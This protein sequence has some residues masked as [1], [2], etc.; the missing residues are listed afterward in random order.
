MLFFFFQQ[1]VHPYQ[2]PKSF[3]R[4]HVAHKMAE[5]A[6]NKSHRYSLS[7]SG[8]INYDEYDYLLTN[9]R[10]NQ[11]HKNVT[12]LCLAALPPTGTWAYI[13]CQRNFVNATFFCQR[14]IP[15]H[16]ETDYCAEV[17][18]TKPV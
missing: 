2:G 11:S 1:N 6:V 8:R 16:F 12:G 14:I 9:I 5:L 17:H 10:Q 15:V 4:L 13:D 18:D 7:K 3:T